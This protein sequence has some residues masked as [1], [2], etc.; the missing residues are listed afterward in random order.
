MKEY[1]Y[2]LVCMW[3]DHHRT[4]SDSYSNRLLD[5]IHPLFGLMYESI[6]QRFVSNPLIDYVK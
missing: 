5:Q 2:K 1:S 3:T 6:V 4:Q